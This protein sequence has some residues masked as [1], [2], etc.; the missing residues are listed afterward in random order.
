VAS[1]AGRTMSAAAAALLRAVGEAAAMALVC[2]PR[3]QG[4]S[5]IDPLAPVE[6]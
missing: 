4:R 2:P 5:K 1:I 6:N 3:C